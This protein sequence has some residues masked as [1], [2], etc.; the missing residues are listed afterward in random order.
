MRLLIVASLLSSTA[1]FA[2]A[3]EALRGNVLVWYDATFFV[4]QSETTSLKLA[5]L[6]APREQRVGR[7]VA[8]K[9]LGTTGDYVQVA[10]AERDCTW[11]QLGTPD[12]LAKLSL[13]VKRVDL[14]PVLTRPYEQAFPNGTKIVLRPGMAVQPAATGYVVALRGDTVA[15]DVPA[16]SIGHSYTM[17]R[18]KAMTITGSV[19]A[20]ARG[21]KATLGD[22]TVALGAWEG[23]P[24]E[25]RGATTVIALEDRCATLHVAVPSAAIKDSDEDQT[26]LTLGGSGSGSLDLRGE[27]YIPTLSPLT[28]GDRVVAYSSKPIYLPVAPTGKSACFERR[29]AIESSVAGLEPDRPDKS[30]EGGTRSG[31]EGGAKS[32][33]KLRLCVPATRVVHEKLRSGRSANGTTRR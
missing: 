5:T 8:M 3:P 9:V 14:A 27:Y 17:E 13:F 33:D 10:P 25:R 12:D 31:A 18:G 23:T 19:L 29:I 2:E 20:V 16:A 28:I 4:D 7:V 32:I 6:D 22:R 30:T 15:V 1:A 24:V 11:S 21:T 26:D